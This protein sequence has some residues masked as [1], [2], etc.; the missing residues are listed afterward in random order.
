MAQQTG[1][2]PQK[3]WA[4]VI[5][6]GVRTNEQTTSQAAAHGKRRHSSLRPVIG[7]QFTT[8]PRLLLSNE[9]G[10]PSFA[11]HETDARGKQNRSRLQTLSDSTEDLLAAAVRCAIQQQR[12][13]S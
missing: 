10:Q 11:A 12:S 2:T 7:A 3:R 8:S 1:V 13:R 6:F 5:S 9:A 4:C